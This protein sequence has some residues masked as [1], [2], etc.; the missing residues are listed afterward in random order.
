MSCAPWST[1][2]ARTLAKQHGRSAC[3]RRS[4]RIFGE[5]IQSPSCVSATSLTRYWRCPRAGA[6][7]SISFKTSQV[8][9]E[10]VER[11]VDSMRASHGA[12]TTI[13]CTICLMPLGAML[14]RS[15]TSLP[16]IGNALIYPRAGPRKANLRSGALDPSEAPT[17]PPLRFAWHGLRQDTA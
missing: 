3:L 5:F 2:D 6:R 17:T 16:R 7:L 9:R 11:I 1:R 12:A 13:V 14:R 4:G 8:C 15:S 10:V